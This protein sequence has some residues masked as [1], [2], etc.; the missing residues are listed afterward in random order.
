[1]GR[2]TGQGQAFLR[3]LVS[4]CVGN[5]EAFLRLLCVTQHYLRPKASGKELL[6]FSRIA[7]LVYTVIMGELLHA[8]KPKFTD[9][10][11]GH[12]CSA[13]SCA[14]EPCELTKLTVL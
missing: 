1:M 14:R 5:A 11:P 2:S 8:Q 12:C 3:V 9:G 10:Q 7:V 13:V 4:K 6:L